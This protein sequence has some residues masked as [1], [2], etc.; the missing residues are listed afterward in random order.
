MTKRIEHMGARLSDNYEHRERLASVKAKV[1]VGDM[2]TVDGRAGKVIAVHSSF[3]VLEFT[4][5]QEL[6]GNRKEKY[7]EY[8]QWDELL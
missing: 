5:Y 3:C 1:K 4:V 6:W 8:F 7:G 2:L